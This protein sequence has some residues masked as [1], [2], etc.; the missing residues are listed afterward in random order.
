VPAILAA[1][2]DSSPSLVIITVIAT[3]ALLAGITRLILPASRRLA[4]ST[5]IVAAVIGAAIAWIPLDTGL[6]AAGG[7]LRLGAG[8]VG[9]IV[10][11]A[12]STSVLLAYKRRRERGVL[13]ASVT[14]LIAAGEGD[15]VEFKSTAR[16]NTRSGAKDPRM[17]DEVVVTVAG[18]MNATG[19]S[20]LLGIDDDGSVHGL[21]DDY[22]VVPGRDRD[23]FEL[24]LRTL[25]AERLGRAV[26]ADVGVSLTE[27]DGRDV[28]RVDVAPADRPVFVG[29]TGGAR[30]ADFYLRVGN[31]T[32]RLLTDEVLDYRARR[33]P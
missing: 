13:G 5:T 23:G 33:W 12:I 25:L 3:G 4:W 17:E 6:V 14:D 9:A 10:A 28:C 19:G 31:A 30:T 24:W 29:S 2:P 26:T 27:V 8:I 21:D 15:R 11:V 7:W 16:W 18:F 20:L 1:M 22:A 32:R